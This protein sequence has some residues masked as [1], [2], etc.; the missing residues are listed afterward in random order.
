MKKKDTNN[1][2]AVLLVIAAIVLVTGIAV[3]FYLMAPSYEQP[4]TTGQVKVFVPVT[5]IV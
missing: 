5:V 4:S 1:L 2:V 3:N